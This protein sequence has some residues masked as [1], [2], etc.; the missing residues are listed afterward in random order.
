MLW[1]GKH[2]DVLDALVVGLTGAVSGRAWRM[3]TPGIF[4]DSGFGSHENIP[5]RV[6]SKTQKKTAGA[7]SGF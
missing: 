6:G 1:R 4:V 5:R 3:D 7:A 2:G